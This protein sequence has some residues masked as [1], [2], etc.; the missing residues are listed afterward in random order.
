MDALFG[1]M[2]RLHERGPKARGLVVDE[3]GVALGP[4]FVLV[5]RTRLG[6]RLTDPSDIDLVRKLVFHTTAPRK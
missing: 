1:N 2:R 5:Q 4:D 6:Y 3:E